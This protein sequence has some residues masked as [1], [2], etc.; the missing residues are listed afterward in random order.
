M[1][2]Q[3]QQTVTFE[4]ALVNRLAGRIGTLEA[5]LEMAHLNL[6]IKDQEIARLTQQLQAAT[7]AAMQEYREYTEP[8]T[9][10]PPTLPNGDST[11]STEGE[12]VS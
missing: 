5:Q 11:V 4:E 3:Q 2:D 7:A 8:M 6:D 10:G 9:S 1:S 12:A